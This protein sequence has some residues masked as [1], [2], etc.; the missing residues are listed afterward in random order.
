MTCARARSSVTRLAWILGMLDGKSSTDVT[1]SFVT[2]TLP[3]RSRIGPR[4][5]WT[6]TLRIWFACARA[7]YCDPA[8]TCSAHRRMKSAAKPT[9]T[10]ALS[11]ATRRASFGVSRYGSTR[12]AR[13]PIRPQA[14][15][16]T[17]AAPAAAG[18]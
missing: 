16:V 11:S 6:R 7:V 1:G 9:T 4:G 14:R 5:A 17:A 10:S 18:C 8:S 15:A 13:C 2:R 12:S 3:C